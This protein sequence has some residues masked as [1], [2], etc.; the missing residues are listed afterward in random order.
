MVRKLEEIEGEL[1]RL[2]PA[3]RASLAKKLLDSLEDLSEEENERL[4]AEEA[5]ARYVDFKAGRTT[6]SPGDEVFARARARKP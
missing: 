3:A 6:A 4:W 2:T 1:L 5:D